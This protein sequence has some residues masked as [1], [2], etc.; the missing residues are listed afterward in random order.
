MIATSA[1]AA[2]ILFRRADTFVDS[3]AKIASPSPM[4]L[5]HGR[6]SP[7]ADNRSTTRMCHFRP[8]A[9]QQTCT[10]PAEEFASVADKPTAPVAPQVSQG[11][12]RR[13]IGHPSRRGPRPCSS[14]TTLDASC[15]P[16]T[17]VIAPAL[18]VEAYSRPGS[19]YCCS[20]CRCCSCCAWPSGD[21]PDCC[22][23]NRRAGRGD[24]GAARLPLAA[25]GTIA[26][27]RCQ[28]RIE[29][30]HPE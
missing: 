15:A 6:N 29:Q 4:F 2:F 14:W 18:A 28:G 1:Q 25:T 27:A 22:S 24:R 19:R 17:T 8:Y 11:R 20:G 5:L 12:H 23:R 7:K 9:M 13:G 21:S 3:S 10:L 26:E 30:T 16:G